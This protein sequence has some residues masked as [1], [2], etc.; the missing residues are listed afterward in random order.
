MRSFFTSLLLGLVVFS[1]AGCSSDGGLSGLYQCEGT[2]T[3]KG[4][5]V[6]GA[7]VT[8]H[9]DGG[10]E[11]RPAGGLT[12]ADGKFKVTTLKSDDGIFPGN[13][14]VTITKYEE[15]G[16]VRRYQDED[17]NTQEERLIKNVLPA[18]Y[19]KAGTSDLT[20]VIEQKRN[21]ADFALVD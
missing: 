10:G 8:F 17:G 19:E 18:K 15:T 4:A 3:Y 12:D 6:V 2:V 9:P 20:A 11:M 16:E 13:Y 14:K 5:P 1:L 7:S 21:T